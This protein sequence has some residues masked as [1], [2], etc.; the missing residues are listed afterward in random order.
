MLLD[1][2]GLLRLQQRGEPLQ[3]RTRDAYHAA[4]TRLTHAYILGEYVALAH[5]RRFPR[6]ALRAIG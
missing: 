4:D 5:A 1:T 6:V 2:S 3:I